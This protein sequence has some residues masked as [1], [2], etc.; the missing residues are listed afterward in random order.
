MSIWFSVT[1]RMQWRIWAEV[2]GGR[3]WILCFNENEGKYSSR[4]R[5]S[6]DGSQNAT[7]WMLSVPSSSI[8][9]VEVEFST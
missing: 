7:S 2:G 4:L 3:D 6:I 1:T 5:S 9:N 8:L